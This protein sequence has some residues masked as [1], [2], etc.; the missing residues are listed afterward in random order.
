LDAKSFTQVGGN[1]T[2]LVL[3][4]SNFIL[5]AFIVE[6]SM[7]SLRGFL[8]VLEEGIMQNLIV[9]I[10]FAH[11]RLQSLPHFLFESFGLICMVA[12]FSQLSD[13]CLLYEFWQFERYLVDS[14]LVLQVATLLCPVSWNRY[15]ITHLLTFKKE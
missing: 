7:A 5:L 9:Y 15:R 3:L 12:L 4:H 1:S 6:V 11:F 13:A 2:W 14:T 8:L 10:N